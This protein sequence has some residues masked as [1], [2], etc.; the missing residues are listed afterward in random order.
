MKDSTF[1]LIG[2]GLVALYIIA[3]KTGSNPL[4]FLTSNGGQILTVPNEPLEAPNIPA[5]QPTG[6]LVALGAPGSDTN[7]PDGIS[8]TLIPGPLFTSPF[9]A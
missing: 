6:T 2:G 4:G 3:A 8:Q 7:T 5:G 1:W 9:Q